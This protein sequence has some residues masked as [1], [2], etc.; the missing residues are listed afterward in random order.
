MPHQ[1]YRIKAA[2]PHRGRRVSHSQGRRKTGGKG[3]FLTAIHSFPSRLQHGGE[4]PAEE[5]AQLRVPP[6]SP[7]CGQVGPRRGEGASSQHV[8]PQGAKEEKETL[9][10]GNG[11]KPRT[12]GS[13]AHLG[14]RLRAVCPR[15]GGGATHGSG[16]QRPSEVR[17]LT[18]SSPWGWRGPTIPHRPQRLQ[19][20]RQG[21]TC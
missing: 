10:K 1:V 12:E 4:V 14:R 7:R 16:G 11:P 15:R 6:A 3:G 17:A 2:P 20:L 5:P 18:L 19:R 9:A 21:K 8:T 13:P